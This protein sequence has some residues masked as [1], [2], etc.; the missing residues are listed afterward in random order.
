[1]FVRIVDGWTT[2]GDSELN[3][4]L[5]TTSNS[6]TFLPVKNSYYI[7]TFNNE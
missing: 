4:V 6:A 7:S 5:E 1:M 2:T 3:G